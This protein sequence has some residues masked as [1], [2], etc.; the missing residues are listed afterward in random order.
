[1]PRAV[2]FFLALLMLTASVAARARDDL[3]IGLTQFPSSLHPAIDSMMA[4]TYVLGM[5]LRPLSAYDSQWRLVCMLCERLPSLENGLARRETTA[6]G[7]AGVALTYTLRADAFWGDGH[8]VG[9]DDVVFAW[10]MGRHP[11]SGVAN[12]EMYRRILAIDVKDA[13]TFTVHLD[14]LTFD[15]NALNDLQ[16]LP[17]HV[18]RPRFIAAPTEYRHRNGYDQDPGNP[19]LY[20][21]PYR[22]TQVVQGSHV[23]LEPNPHWRGPR[24]DFS[25]VVVRAVENT[26]ALEA[27]LLSGGVDMVAGELGL[28]LEQAVAFDKRADPRFKVLFKSGLVYEHI[29]VNLGAPALSDRRVRQA[30]MLGLDRDGL[31]RQLFDG[32]QPVAHTSVNP[33][34]GV[35]ADDVPKYSHDPV[36]AARLLDQAGWKLA[37]ALRRNDRGETLTVELITTA[38]NR[39]RELVSQVIQG[40]WRRLGVDVRLRAEPPRVFFGETV[41]RRRFSHL[42]L[43]A[44]VSAPE[45]VPRTTLHSGQIPDAANNWAGQNY[46]GYADPRMDQLLDAIET[47]LDRPRRVE[48][49]RQL[50]HL[51]AQDLPALPLYFR[52]DGTILPKGLDGVVPTGHK[53]PSTLWIETWR[54]RR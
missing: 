12:A 54:W 48:L 53:D 28:P 38:G 37:G 46:S 24:P 40:Q 13:K 17:A 45:S 14:R 16:P 51:Y 34:D 49:W 7:K 22:L 9:S 23:T 30:L 42:A 44:W 20:N 52:A 3:V 26:A 18:E 10:E 41:T 32:R 27:Q 39:S 6:Q 15:Y 50:Q 4:K 8:P 19:G 31:N 2:T 29:D 21:G 47:E 35:H 33:L 11:G 43:F 1:M 25:R 5:A 36:Q